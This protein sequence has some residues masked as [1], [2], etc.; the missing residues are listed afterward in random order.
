MIRIGR[1][2][3]RAPTGIEQLLHDVR[4]ALRLARGERE[5]SAA[6]VLTLALGIGANTTVFT[7]VQAILL[8]PLPYSDAD[9]LVRII[10]NVPPEESLTGGPERSSTMNAD[11]F[12]EWRARTRTLSHMVLSAPTSMTLTRRDDSVRLSGLQVSPDL[13]PMLRASPL[14]GTVF[15]RSAE[16]PEASRVIVLSYSAWQRYFGGAIDVIGRVVRLDDAGYTVTLDNALAIQRRQ[17]L[18][19]PRIVN[20]IAS[21]RGIEAAAF[22]TAIRWSRQ[23]S[24]WTSRTPPKGG[25]RRFPEAGRSW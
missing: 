12:L 19:A 13:W 10:E 17:L 23:D 14:R 5:F 15:S 22:A 8:R 18:D 6:V 16:A 9:R 3:F 11:L 21:L 20:Q 7:A 4:H 2:A 25:R 24:S 1:L